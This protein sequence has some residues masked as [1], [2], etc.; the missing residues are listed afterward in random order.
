MIETKCYLKGMFINLALINL[1]FLFI[2][3]ICHL[4]SGGK[5]CQL[6]KETF[7]AIGK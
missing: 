5:R 1:P 4:F 7:I 3:T 2:Y 6:Q